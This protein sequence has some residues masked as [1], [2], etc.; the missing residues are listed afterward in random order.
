[1]GMRGGDKKSEPEEIS[2]SDIEEGNMISI[3]TLDEGE[4]AERI[5]VR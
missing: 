3:W 5:M 1:M 4:V 2:K